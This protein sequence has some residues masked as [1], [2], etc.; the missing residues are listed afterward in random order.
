MNGKY[1]FGCGKPLQTEEAFY[2]R[3]CARKLFGATGIPSLNVTQ[4]ELNELAKNTF[5][6]VDSHIVLMNRSIFTGECR[7][8]I[9][10][11]Y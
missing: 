8:V 5:E 10:F 9:S 7:S 2:H 4:E 11:I 6:H 3:S 1:F